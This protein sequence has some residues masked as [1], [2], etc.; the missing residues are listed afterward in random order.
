MAIFF[1]QAT[2]TYNGGTVN[3]NVTTGEILETLNVTKT[4]VVEEYT[5]SSEITYAINMTNT[6][7]APVTGVT[8]T[9]DLGA[10][11]FGTE[12]LIPLDYVEGSVKYFIDGVLQPSPT[13]S[14]AHLLQNDSPNTPRARHEAGTPITA[15]S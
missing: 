10:Y 13:T 1:N 3:S 5:T 11:P 15:L 12:T 2:L 6:G 9:D 14:N 8:L 4:A 7:T